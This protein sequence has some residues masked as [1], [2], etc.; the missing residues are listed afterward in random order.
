MKTFLLVLAFIPLTFITNGCDIRDLYYSNISEE[1]DKMCD[2]YEL[3][4]CGELEKPEYTPTRYLSIRNYIAGMDYH[5][6]YDDGDSYDYML[7]DYKY[8]DCEDYTITL[9]ED[10]LMLGMIDNAKWMYGQ[11]GDTYHAW[12]LTTIE[13]TEYIIDTYYRLGVPYEDVRHRYNELRTVM[14]FSE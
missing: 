10:M 7:G 8:G 4:I 13:G 11:Y 1:V 5:Y 3:H 9:M 6:K 12:L 2:K 14:E